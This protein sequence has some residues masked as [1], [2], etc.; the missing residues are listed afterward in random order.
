MALRSERARD[1]VALAVCVGA[2]CL[3]LLPSTFGRALYLDDITN[4][5]YPLMWHYGQGL[6]QGELPLWSARLFGGYPA[7]AAGQTAMCYPPHLLLYSLFTPLT[8]FKLTYLLHFALAAAGM[9]LFCRAEGCGRWGALVGGLLWGLNGMAVA[10]TV[11]ANYLPAF[12]W[13]GWMLTAARAWLL[14]RSRPAGLAAGAALLGLLF[15]SA[16]PQMALLAVVALAAYVLVGVRPGRPASESL[17][18]AARLGRLA[19]VLGGG[20]ALAAVQLV[21]EIFYAREAPRAGAAAMPGFLTAGAFTLRDLPR[22]LLPNLWG[23]PT[24]GSWG[25]PDFEFWETCAGIGVTGF[26]LAAVRLWQRGLDRLAWFGLALIVAG[27]LLVPGGRS[28]ISAALSHVPPFDLFRCPG[29]FAF[30]LVLG[31]TCLAAAGADSLAR[32]TAR[33]GRGPA[34]LVLLALAAALLWRIAARGTPGPGL[35]SRPEAWAGLLAAAVFAFACWALPTFPTACRLGPLAVAL[36]AELLLFAFSFAVTVPDAALTE[37]PASASLFVTGPL[38]D[39]LRMHLVEGES[40]IGGP[41]P[42]DFAANP[43][44]LTTGLATTYGVVPLFA[45]EAGGLTPRRALAANEALRSAAARALAGDEGSQHR[46]GT[47]CSRLN[48]GWVLSPRRCPDPTMPLVTTDCGLRLYRNPG[49][50]PLCYA[51][52]VFAETE[53][54]FEPPEDLPAQQLIPGRLVRETPSSAAWDFVVPRRCLVVFC[55]TMDPGWEALVDG[56]PAPVV[57][58]DKFCVGVFVP[59]G[60][61]QVAFRYVSD[62]FRLG[63]RV[64]LATLALL[65]GWVW[66][67]RRRRSSPQGEPST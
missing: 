50:R 23:T 33:L 37:A 38:Y 52:S 56:Q 4:L 3:F 51:T 53:G 29:R 5:F 42:T 67:S 63:L 62:W 13:M 18:L 30:W 8:A 34:A 65:V 19:L 16:H 41:I 1:A 17:P 54:Q 7:H 47:L 64:S 9:F 66:W 26:G 49:A 21:P 55:Q 48:I 61:H 36:G 24:D 10:H 31:A 59:P 58:A 39:R 15:L 45:G 32:G 12:A 40:R 6:H 14:P 43:R 35:W 60:R 44:R 11:H 25:R 20:L 46:F 57:R 2:G 27:A 28:P 22:L